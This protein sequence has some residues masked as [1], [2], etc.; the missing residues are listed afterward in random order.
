MSVHCSVVVNCASTW[1]LPRKV[2]VGGIS[3]L[4]APQ[5]DQEISYFHVSEDHSLRVQLLGAMIFGRFGRR[6]PSP[7]AGNVSEFLKQYG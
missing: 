5:G 3:L 6:E 4:A 1:L 2:G 7:I